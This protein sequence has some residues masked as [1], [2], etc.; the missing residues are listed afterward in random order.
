[1]IKQ[2]LLAL[3]LVASLSAC[4]GKKELDIGMAPP[5]QIPDAPAYLTKKAEKLP[6]ITDPSFGGIMLDGAD[7]DAKYN[8]VAIRLN[9]LIDY[10][11]CIQE[12]INKKKDIAKCLK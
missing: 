8:D 7:T 4:G 11:L 12:S 1:M 10:T 5:V 3:A 2:T 6:E 9:L